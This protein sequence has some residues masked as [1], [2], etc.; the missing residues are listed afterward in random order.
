[1][2]VNDLAAYGASDRILAVGWLERGQE[3]AVGAVSL[4]L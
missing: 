4:V 2:W 3:Y 1:M